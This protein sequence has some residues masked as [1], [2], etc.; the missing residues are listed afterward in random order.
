MDI[1]VTGRHCTVSDDLREQVTERLAAVEKLRDRVIRTEIEFT[2]HN[3]KGNPE[4]D[5]VCDITLRSR[6]PVIRA[7][8][9]ADDKRAAFEKALERLKTQLRKAS[10]RRKNHRGLRG[11]EIVAQIAPEPVEAADQVETRTVAGIEVTGDGPLVVREKEFPGH[12]L[13]LAQALDEMELVG[14]D[15]FLFVDADKN[16]PS[17]VYRR[18]GYDYGVIR[19]TEPA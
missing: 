2:A 4:D 14:H 17:V 8:G 9:R 15:F 10:D 6:G 1:I 18:K 13:T 11:H 16:Q 3:A 12:P 5:V 19:L 7:E